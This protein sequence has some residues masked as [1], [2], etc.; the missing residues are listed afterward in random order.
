[1]S[2]YFLRVA[3]S[4]FFAFISFASLA[5]VNSLPCNPANPANGG[6]C[7]SEC[8]FAPAV[9][10]GCN[11]FDGID[12]D[13]DGRIDALDPD[14]ASYYGLEFLGSGSDCSITPNVTGSFAGFVGTA[15]SAQNTS[16]TQARIA[17]GDVDGDGIPDIVTTSKWNQQIRVVATSNNQADGKSA[18]DVKADYKTPGKAIFP[19][20]NFYFELEIAIADI[21][22]NGKGEMFSVVSKRKNAKA[23]P[24]G[25]WLVGFTYTS[26]Q[27]TPLWNAVALGNRRPGIIGIADFDG[28]G[29]AEVYFKDEIYAAETGKLLARGAGGEWSTVVNAAPV[30]VNV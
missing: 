15:S 25:Y 19:S 16:D 11:C 5:Q 1:M 9:E 24:E 23:T 8:V 3:G 30:A 18:G 10:R 26:G 20:G 17:V 7:P 22:K 13:G 21:N 4:L 6:N 29:L 27:L 2:K 28:D 14:C 12:N